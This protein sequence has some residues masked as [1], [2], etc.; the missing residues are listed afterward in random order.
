MTSKNR[1]APAEPGEREVVI[2]FDMASGDMA[3][4]YTAW[5]GWYSRLLRNPSA[6]LLEVRRDERGRLTGAEFELPA[7]LVSIRSKRRSAKKAGTPLA[8][9][10]GGR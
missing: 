1:W 6:R 5:P 8:P 7:A 4:V 3:Y 2:Q 9:V 10:A